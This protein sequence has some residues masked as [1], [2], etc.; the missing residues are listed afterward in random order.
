MEV[1]S[2]VDVGNEVGVSWMKATVVVELTFGSAG[3]SLEV[4]FSKLT[5]PP[6]MNDMSSS[7]TLRYLKKA[8]I[9]GTPT[10]RANW[11]SS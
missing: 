5:W 11:L 3:V 1:S 2:R 4:G 8:L 10:D 6:V 9:A 7:M